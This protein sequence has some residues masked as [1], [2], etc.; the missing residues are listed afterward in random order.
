MDSEIKEKTFHDSCEILENY[1]NLKKYNISKPILSKY[2]KTKILGLRSAQISNGAKPLISVPKHITEVLDIAVEEL[3]QRK[4]PFII[5]RKVGNKLEYWKIEDLNYFIKQ[6]DERL[7][8][9]K[10][11]NQGNENLCKSASSLEA[12]K[13]FLTLIVLKYW[14]HRSNFRQGLML[15]RCLRCK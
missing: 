9:I 1:D 15:L 5:E 11:Y 4:I 3:K 2:E 14:L 7:P 12:F 8:L 6:Y 10:E 13:T